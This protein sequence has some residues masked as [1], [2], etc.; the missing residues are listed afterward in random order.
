MKSSVAGFGHADKVSVQKSL[1]ILFKEKFNFKT[2]DESDALAIAYCCAMSSELLN[3][4][5]K[6]LEV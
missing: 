4:K 6:E 2:H 3:I 5:K 1:E